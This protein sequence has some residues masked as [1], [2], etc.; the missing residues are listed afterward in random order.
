MREMSISAGFMRKLLLRMRAHAD[1]GISGG[2]GDEDER[3]VLGAHEVDMRLEEL[4]ED[5][6]DLDADRRHELV[7]LMWVWRGDFDEAG[8]EEALA[9]AEERDVGPTS[10]YLLA[11]P[12]AADE[13]AAGLEELG[14]WH[15]MDEGRN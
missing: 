2:P 7:A 3:A 15:V 11:H 5:I 13:I 14:H 9:L 12:Q 4:V 6:D 10:A 1:R 8:W